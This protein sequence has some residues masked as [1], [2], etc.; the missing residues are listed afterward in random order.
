M[1]KPLGP[2]TPIVRSG[3]LLV[4]SGQLGMSD[5]AL[6]GGGVSAETA[7]AVANL[8]TL[9]EGEGASLDD[10][11]KTTVFLT[12]MGDFATMNEAYIAAFGDHRPARSTIGVAALPLP[13]AAV[14][15]EAWARIA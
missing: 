6:V 11:I 7:Q 9:L 5:G 2:Y 4:V 15:I 12:D 8:A 10:V 13:G 14:E 3:D 1:A